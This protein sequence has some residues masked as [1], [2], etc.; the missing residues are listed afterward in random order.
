V[1]LYDAAS[2][3]ELKLVQTESPAHSVAWSP[4]RQLLAVGANVDRSGRLDGTV[5]LWRVADGALTASLEGHTRP[6]A[7]LAWSLDGQLLASGSD[8]GTIRLWG[9]R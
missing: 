3:A 1:Y 2:L 6:V 7:D 9:V 4:D 8:D 5:R